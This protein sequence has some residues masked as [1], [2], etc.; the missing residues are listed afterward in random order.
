MQSEPSIAEGAFAQ[1]VD[2]LI[3]GAGISGIGAAH[4][5]QEKCP[6]QSYAILERRESMGGTWDLFRYPGIRSD[7]DMYTLGYSFYPWR[8]PKS[9]A[10]G[11][12]ILEYVKDTAREFGIDKK[13]EHGVHVKS[14]SW[15]SETSRWTVEAEATDSGEVRRFDCGFLFMCSGYYNYDAGY[16]PKFEG[17]DDYEGRVVHPQFWTPDIEYTGKQVVVIGSGATA[18]TLVPE[19]AKQAEHVTMLQRSPTYVVSAPGRDPLAVWL[20]ERVP[21]NLAYHLVR[22]KNILLGIAMFNFCKRRPE[23]AKRLILKGVEKNL[24]PGYDVKTHFNP[25]YNPWDQRMCLVPDADLFDSINAGTSSVVTDRID[26]FTKKGIRLQSGA[27]LEADLVVTAT[28]LDLQLMGGL[29]VTVDGERVDPA[30]SMTY[31]SMMFSDIPNLALSFGYTN[32]SWTLKC[33]ITCDYVTRL[34]NFMQ[35]KGYTECR[36]RVVDSKVEVESMLNLTSGYIQRSADAFPKQGTKAPWRLYQ[37]Y[38]LDKLT[39]GLSRIQDPALEF[40]RSRR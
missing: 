4:H 34:L 8:S 22:W 31:K 5:L 9:I 29:V 13:I 3:I 11:P 12:A 37:N 19:L 30:K 7:S 32:A 14:A 17:L 35:K 26:T 1:S 15:C 33:D 18:V 38:L 40:G 10:D 27:E 2:V 23:A 24:N 21:Q 39:I 36:P 25:R 16:T 6:G 28:G 20:R